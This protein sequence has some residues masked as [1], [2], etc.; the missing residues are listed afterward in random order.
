MCRTAEVICGAG[1]E[2]M[3]WFD[4]G[5]AVRRQL[6]KRR[7]AYVAV[8]ALRSVSRPPTNAISQYDFGRSSTF[9]PTNER[10]SCSVIGAMRA[11]VTSRNSRS[12]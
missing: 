10:M 6:K 8:A 4:V 1:G 7:I 3:T 5:T 12:T 11:I 2:P 9:S